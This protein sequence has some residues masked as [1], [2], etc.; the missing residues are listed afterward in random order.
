[1]HKNIGI[2]IQTIYG[3]IYEG[4]IQTYDE[5]EIEIHQESG[6]LS[7]PRN[8]IYRIKLLSTMH[9]FKKC[10]Y[11]LTFIEYKGHVNYYWSTAV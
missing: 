3:N 11:H 9:L 8:R 1:M 4:L 5:D 10:N 6:N 7:I 2:I